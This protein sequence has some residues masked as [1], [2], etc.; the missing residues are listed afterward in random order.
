MPS[1][2]SNDV[3]FF[4]LTEYMIQNTNPHGRRVNHHFPSE[5]AQLSCGVALS[6][7]LA[8]TLGHLFLHLRAGRRLGLRLSSPLIS[9]TPSHERDQL[10]HHLPR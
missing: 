6:L 5:T 1:Q 9:L 2:R 10:H 7:S 8:R 3:F 4:E